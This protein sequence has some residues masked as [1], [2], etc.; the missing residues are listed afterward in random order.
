MRRLC[1]NHSVPSTNRPGE[2]DRVRSDRSGHPRPQAMI[3]FYLGALVCGLL[4]AGC[5]ALTN[6]ALPGIPVRLLPEEL[7]GKSVEGMETIPLN[8]LGQ[9]QPDAYRV[10]PND[11][12]GIWIEGILGEI[13]Q[14][15]PL[16]PPIQLDNVQLPPATGYPIQV[17]R[18]GTISL[19]LLIQPLNVAGKTLAEVETAIRDAYESRDLLKALKEKGR[20]RIVVSLARPRTYHILVLREDAPFPNQAIVSTQTTYGSPE[21]V[22]ISR[23]GTGWELTIPAYNNDVLTALAKTGGLPGTDALDEVVIQRNARRGFKWDTALQDFQ[24]HGVPGAIPHSSIIR[25]P[26][27]VRHGTPLP[28]SAEDITLYDGDA[29]YIPARQERLFYTGGLLGSGQHILP[30]DYDLD[31]LEA[32]ARTRGSLLNGSFVG[33]LFYGSIVMPGLGQPSP[34]LV[35]VIRKLPCGGQVPITVD[36]ARAIKNPRERILM[37]PGDFLILQE[38]P[39][40]AVVRWFTQMM[41]FVWIG[42]YI[43]TPWGFGTTTVSA[44][45]GIAPAT[46][47]PVGIGIAAPQPSAGALPGTAAT[48][49]SSGVAPIGIGVTT[50]VNTLTR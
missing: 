36:I 28:Y 25:I 1:M 19:P 41:D 2:R 12:L 20:A 40:Q 5:A 39:E 24:A 44:P 37:Q 6:P 15:P 14:P 10:G 4:G 21:Y 11:V 47:S 46:T 30:R 33:T 50:P 34:T 45:G 31:V 26:L 16:L 43:Q 22:G 23:K 49:S 48:S 35:T 27:R 32:L 17:R 9:P 38:T 8:L 29:V 18:E 3:G 42:K 7:R 13:G